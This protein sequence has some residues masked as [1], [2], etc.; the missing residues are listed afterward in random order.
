MAVLVAFKS[1]DSIRLFECSLKHGNLAMVKLTD[2]IECFMCTSELGLLFTH[3][4]M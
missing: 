2:L 3:V 1:K 4:I